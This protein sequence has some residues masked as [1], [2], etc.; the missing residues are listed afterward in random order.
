MQNG[1]LV[2]A[3]SP[4]QNVIIPE[5]RV[6]TDIAN[7]QL[8]QVT[9]IIPDGAASDHAQ[10]ND[11]SGPSW[12]ASI[13]NAIGN[14]QYWTNTAIFI[15]WDDWGGWFD[16]VAPKV[17]NS[18]EYGFRVPLIVVSPYAQAKHV[19][20]NTHDFGS[21]LKFIEENYGLPSLGYADAPADD[22]SDCFNFSQTPLAF[23][24]I[25][26]PMGAEHFLNDTR[27]PTDPDDD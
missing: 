23:Q 5:K 6:L 3:G 27:P 17:I 12:V 26:A 21:I 7:N 8:A 25:S 9:W 15:T 16:H 18:Y 2:C 24:T 11:G 19:S 1:Q 13:V 20:H 14:S 22:F 4:W 10:I